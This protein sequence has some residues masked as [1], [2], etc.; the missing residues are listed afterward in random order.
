MVTS[1][2]SGITKKLSLAERAQLALKERQA[3]HKSPRKQTI[4]RRTPSEPAV[5]SFAQQRLWFLD[6]L[7]P[8]SQIYNIPAA[9]R[10]RG[11]L[12]LAALTRTFS[13]VVRRHE[14]LRTT[15]PV[16]DGQATL[17]IGEAVELAVSFRDL[18]EMS[19]AE[20]EAEAAREA[21]AETA[22][23]FDLS[24]GPLVRVSVLKLSEDEHVLLVTMHHIVSDAWSTG[25]F[26]REMS[27]LYSAF[28]S[29]ADSP[30]EE[31]PIQYADYAAWQRQH[32]SGENLERQLAYWRQ[33]L[34]GAPALLELPTDRPRPPVQ[35]YRGATHSFVLPSELT[36]ALKELS[37]GEGC[38]LFM[39]LL[40]GW[41]AL[42]SR[43]SNQR[44]VV[45]GTPIANRTRAEVEG[46]IG[47]FVNTLALRTDF[48]GDPTFRELLAR[49]REVTLGAY[50]HQEVPF[51]RLVEELQP[52]RSLSHQPLFQVMF[53][54]QN[55]PQERL[56][57]SGLELGAWGGGAGG[58]VAKFD[59]LL[60]VTEAGGRLAATLEYSTDL[61]DAETVERL[62]QHFERLLRGVVEDADRRVSDIRLR[63]AEEEHRI[64]VE[65]NETRREYPR[66]S[67][68]TQL[69]EAQVG[70]TP[71]AVALVCEGETVSYAELNV[72]AN[73]LARRL[74]E[75]GVGAESRVAVM[76]ERSPALV[77]ALLAV[78]KAGGAYVP[79][80]P[81]YPA[82]RL[83][84]MLE[85]SGAGVVLTQESLRETVPGTAAR[86]LVL[87]AE[88]ERARVAALGGED[89]PCGVGPENLAYV[90]YTSGSTGRPKGVGVC[91]LSVSN[92]LETMQSWPG[93]SAQDSLLALTSICFDISV[94]ELFLPLCVGAHFVLA[95]RRDATSD[96]ALRHLLVS[97]GV[98][99][100][101][102]TPATYN[103][104]LA[105]GAAMPGEPLRRVMCGG[106]AMSAALGQR[107][108]D[109]GAEA[110]N[111]YGPTETTVYSAGQRVTAAPPSGRSGGVPLGRP[112]E[113]TQLYVLDA[114]LRPVPV[115]VCGELYIG[116]DGL[117][118]GYL[119]RP[120]LTAERFV[121][122]PFSPRQGARMYR[123]GDL[124]HYLP[125][126][127]LAYMGRS[128]NQIKLR[129]FRI[130][131][132]EV[133]AAL[134][135]CPGVKQATVLLREESDGEQ[136][137]VAYVVAE[138]AREVSGNQLRAALSQRL[139]QHMMPAAYVLLEAMPL[140][141]NGKIDA[142]Q[143]RALGV[144]QAEVGG[145]DDEPTTEMEELLSSIYS[146]VL[147]VGRVGIKQNFFEM[148]GHSLLA[149]Q[150][151]HLIR[152]ALEI[153]LPLRSIFDEPTV[154]GL[155]LLVTDILN[156]EEK[157]ALGE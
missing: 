119:N 74:R 40:A 47:F 152:Q 157:A 30:L 7:E 73:R 12:N 11:P 13:E 67:S 143:L 84:F 29:G 15:F 82:E 8:G 18:T 110:W 1:E 96:E 69:F 150:V 68:L 103:L 51:E 115:G 46:L 129:G 65:W 142:Q 117:A 64:V 156:E 36:S 43:Y 39:T 125:D 85:D 97:S 77:V 28:T 135:Q 32:L 113:N 52:E 111:L 124:A 21:S 37:R 126:G 138:A 81:E 151:I 86:V 141:P 145:E 23:G 107:L 58:A 94:V 91:H 109:G 79:L 41:Q 134:S 112:V 93:L 38:T 95:T 66:G 44:E 123:T 71:E 56:E 116:G 26:I 99:V 89:L 54:L 83:R 122:D 92:L 148:G 78:L 48:S 80:D 17:V 102:A 61:F 5:L 6:Q 118:R 9:L 106:E 20:R 62:Q 55:A 128:D 100:M 127:V 50:A 104:L 19:P 155:A 133:E 101:Q 146:E 105:S 153:D 22:R 25:I 121:P 49:V 154:A 4:F 70:L 35:T 75:E 137:L 24:A 60:S 132:G 120:A 108:Q 57:L 45:V 90:I 3:E 16:V 130:E 2:A 87:D 114:R 147:K 149:T 31:L 14:V 76:L 98:T 33:Q 27:A 34:G 63:S 72:R 53:V 59:L 140:T 139:P 136:R 42:L 131:L 88:N 144:E 10:L